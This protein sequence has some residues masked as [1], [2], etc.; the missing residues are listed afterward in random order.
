M[1]FPL[2]PSVL[3]FSQSGVVEL[4]SSRGPSRSSSSSTGGSGFTVNSC[5]ISRD[6]KMLA[7]GAA[8][9]TAR[10]S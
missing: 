1:T 10:V 6:G 7:A 9:C 5:V 4:A 3:T 8:D 2:N